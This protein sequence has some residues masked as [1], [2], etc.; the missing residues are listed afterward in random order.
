MFNWILKYAERPFKPGTH[1]KERYLIKK[2][3]GMGSYGIS[4]LAEDKKGQKPAVVKQLRSYKAQSK[5]GLHSFQ[6]EA[7]ILSTL[8]E[9]AFPAYYE[10]FQW[11]NK[12]FIA[13]EYIDGETFED[14]IFIKK[15]SYDEKE[16]FH[17]LLKVLMAV[18]NLH[19]KEIVH[20]DLRI[21]NI[22]LKNQ[23][24][25]IID[26]GLARRMSKENEESK[27]ESKYTKEKKLFRECS[28]RSDFFAL[29]HFVLF[30]LYSSFEPSTKKNSCWEEELELSA[31]AKE[32]IKRMLQLQKPFDSIDE[33]IE[34]V[35]KCTD[36]R[37]Q[38]VI[39][40]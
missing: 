15:D 5:K 35:T 25:H 18:K 13:M 9:T 21:P 28:Y 29:G 40:Q 39:F 7:E 32:I 22:L 20:R 27:S 26:F 24:I 10:D 23:S 11:R 8:H 30:L 38:N 1:I 3:L 6:R 37:E 14:L 4:Y 16:S 19:E 33:L 17:I 36:G 2:V 31:V 12:N 34:E